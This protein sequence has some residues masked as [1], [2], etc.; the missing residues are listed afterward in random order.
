MAFLEQYWNGEKVM[1]YVQGTCL[2]CGFTVYGNYCDMCDSDNT[3]LTPVQKKGFHD[4]NDL[5][6]MTVL[7]DLSTLENLAAFKKWQHEDGT[8]DGMLLLPRN[9]KAVK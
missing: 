4:I 9:T 7:L 8:K 1:S 2:D 6:R 3:D 5:I